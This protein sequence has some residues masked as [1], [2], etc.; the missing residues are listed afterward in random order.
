MAWELLCNV[1]EEI[2]FQSFIFK[3]KLTTQNIKYIDVSNVMIIFQDT[4]N[5]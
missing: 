5:N 2:I 1:D 4:K 3:Y